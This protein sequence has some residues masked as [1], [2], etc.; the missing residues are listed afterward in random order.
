MSR[1]VKE[2]VRAARADPSP[3]DQ[4]LDA[5]VEPTALEQCC[6]DHVDVI[7]VLGRSAPHRVARMQ[8]SKRQDCV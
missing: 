1:K 2:M 3:T 5:D 4:G 7:L 8:K 6:G